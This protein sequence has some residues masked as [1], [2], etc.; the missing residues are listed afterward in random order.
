MSGGGGRRLNRFERRVPGTPLEEPTSSFIQRNSA[1]DSVCSCAAASCHC[2]AGQHRHY[3]PSLSPLSLDQKY[4]ESGISGLHCCAGYGTREK[5][6][7]RAGKKEA[8]LEPLGRSSDREKSSSPVEQDISGGPLPHDQLLITWLSYL[9]PPTGGNRH[10]VHPSASGSCVSSMSAVHC[11][12]RTPP[13]P[14]RART[15]ARDEETQ[16]LPESRRTLSSTQ[17]G[18]VP[19]VACQIC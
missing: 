8:N 19:T 7:A 14:P 1:R 9:T 16:D 18:Q 5:R 11:S 6:A 12:A 13:P 15:A 3:S 10:S 17:L 2:P 4:E